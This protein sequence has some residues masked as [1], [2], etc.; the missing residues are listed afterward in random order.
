MRK[1]KQ[2]TLELL[3]PA[4]NFEIFK[5]VVDTKCDA[6]YFGGQSLN[7]RMIRKGFNF[8]N[9]ELKEA[10]DIAHAKGKKTYIT[11]NNLISELEIDEARTFLTYLDE[12]KPDGLIVQDFAIIELIRE[13]GL[14][15]PVHSSVM[16]NVHNIPMVNTLKAYEV[17]RV[18]LSREMTL[19][20]AKRLGEATGIETEYFTHG[21][22]CI[23]HGSQCYHSSIV[24]GMS[25]NRGRCLKP[26]RW[27]YK[28][29]NETET[30]YPMAVKDLSLYE[31]LP[32]LIDA[33][34]TSFKLEGRMRE[35]DF[36]SSII[37]DYGDAMDRF[38][39][40]SD[41]FDRHLASEKIFETRKRDLSTAY[42]FGKPG[43]D[44]LNTRYEGTGKFY[45]TGKVFSVPTEELRACEDEV[46]KL[47]QYFNS[48]RSNRFERSEI[49]VKVNNVAQATAAIQ[50][51]AE[52][53]LLSGD[54]LLPDA[55]W[56]F[57]DVKMLY[58]LACQRG[59]S[60]YLG[61]PRMM[62]DDQV[63][64]VEERMLWPC[65]GYLVGNLGTLNLLKNQGKDIHVDFSMNTYNHKTLAFYQRE[66]AQS[67]TASIELKYKELTPLLN[68]AEEIAV[69]AY[70]R[71]S[72]MYFEHDFYDSL[73]VNSTGSI[74]LT[75]EAGKFEI[76]KDHL[77]RNHLMT[78][79]PIDLRGL[80]ASLGARF[81]HVEA[82]LMS[83]DEIV[84]IVQELRAKNGQENM[85]KSDTKDQAF[86]PLGT[87]GALKFE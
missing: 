46:H 71:V 11:V 58:D 14:K 17:E 1:F 22:M 40:S 85:I 52:R 87:L 61:F 18:V 15:L 65:H 24:F 68:A 66:G 80:V 74:V 55:D 64:Y 77:G 29:P 82:L 44:N 4:G 32:E 31:Y 21:D 23:A 72:S 3:A 84:S 69:I 28:V 43:K 51:G 79:K 2:Q 27:G 35:A 48:E 47:N 6:I 78:E 7:M 54:V 57:D 13:L 70:G 59:N 19:S 60:I 9:E 26:C 49:F 12:I 38:I 16:M 8:S 50:S 56:T 36:I 41:S 30:T 67:A 5:K 25:S 34:I 20:E 73:N 62:R 75:N 45:S 76:F 63:G 39:E 86:N 10:I 81:L 83:P 53:I 37:N 42:A 33:G